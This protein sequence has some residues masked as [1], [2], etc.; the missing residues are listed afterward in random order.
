M[1]LVGPVF[2]LLVGTNFLHLGF[3]AERFDD[4]KPWWPPTWCRYVAEILVDYQTGS[5]AI[6]DLMWQLPPGTTVRISPPYMVYPP[7]FY[8]PKLHY[9]DQLSETKRVRADLLPLPDYLYVGRVEP[10]VILAPAHLAGE[11][12]AGL[13]LRYGPGSYRLTKVLPPYWGYTSKPEIPAHFFLP[14][15]TDWGRFSG[16]AVLVRQQSPVAKDPALATDP[17]DP[18]ALCRLGIAQKYSG[19]ADQAQRNFEAALRIDPDNGLAHFQLGTVLIAR[20]R[21]AEAVAHYEAVI[22]LLPDD[23]PA[24]INL[25]TA[26][27]AQG[28]MEDARRQY[29][30]ALRIQPDSAT[31]HYNLGNIA[32]RRRRFDEAIYHYQAALKSRFEYAKAHVNLGVALLEVDRPEEAVS[33]FREALRIEPSLIEAHVGLGRGLRDCGNEHGAAEELKIALGL[34]TPGSLQADEINRLL[35]AKGD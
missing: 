15:P 12:R 25:G 23:L 24:R 34:A 4:T 3:L 14:P 1:L 16:M 5:E 35:E 29:V 33:H 21:F 2:F 31:A 13:D 26:Y 11:M 32:L 19:D 18:D 30:A 22:R 20:G 7:M 6:V 10:E 8:A 17:T 27:L 9:C 28:R